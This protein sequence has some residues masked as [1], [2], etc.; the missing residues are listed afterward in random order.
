MRK[1]FIRPDETK[2]RQIIA[3]ASGTAA[4]VILRLAWCAGLTPEEI[5]ALAW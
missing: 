1:D 4:E 5:R 3:D 2:L